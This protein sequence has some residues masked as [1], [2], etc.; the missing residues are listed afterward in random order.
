MKIVKLILC[1]FFPPVAAAL[2]VGP[3]LHLWINIGLTIFFWLPGIVHAFWLVLS[4]KK[5]S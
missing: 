4:D 2:Q 1:F 3:T 5:G